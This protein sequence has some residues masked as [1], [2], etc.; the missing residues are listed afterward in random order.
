MEK[1]VSIKFSIE[2]KTRSLSKKK[3][4]IVRKSRRMKEKIS[5]LKDKI[6]ILCKNIFYFYHGLIIILN[7][8]TKNNY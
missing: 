7:F 5:Y 4:Q 1:K 3:K 8:I 2:V 6:K